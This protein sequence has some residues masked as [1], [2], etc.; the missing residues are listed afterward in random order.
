MSERDLLFLVLFIVVLM[1][2]ASGFLS[3]AR[4][5]FLKFRQRNNT[6]D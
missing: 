1:P 3:E 4:K 2:Y 6:H 5:D